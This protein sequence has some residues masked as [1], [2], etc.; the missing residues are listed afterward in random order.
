L[1]GAARFPESAPVSR[2][3]EDELDRDSKVGACAIHYAASPKTTSA[4]RLKAWNFPLRVTPPDAIN[5]GYA[6]APNDAKDELRA[7]D[8]SEGLSDHRMTSASV[9]QGPHGVFQ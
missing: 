6:P 1:H 8:D 2:A 9:R 7:A 3:P 5:A 4:T